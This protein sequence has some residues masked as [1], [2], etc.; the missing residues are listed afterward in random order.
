MG[1]GFEGGESLGAGGGVVG[2]GQGSHA[3]EASAPRGLAD[4]GRGVLQ[5]VCVLG[6]DGPGAAMAGYLAAGGVDVVLVTDSVEAEAINTKGL[7]IDSQQQVLLVTDGLRATHE[8]NP[9][10]KFDLVVLTGRP[11]ETDAVLSRSRDVIAASKAFVSVQNR[12]DPVIPKPEGSGPLIGA[13]ITEFFERLAPGMIIARRPTDVDVFAGPLNDSEESAELAEALIAAFNAGG[14]VAR[15][16]EDI[17]HVMLEKQLQFAN[18]STWMV[19]MLPGAGDFTLVD[20][21]ALPEGAEQWV[22]TCRELLAVYHAMGYQPRDFYGPRSPLGTIAS[23]PDDAEAKAKILAIGQRHVASGLKVR[24]WMHEDI[25]KRQKTEA[26]AIFGPFIKEGV[27]RGLPVPL[28]S[29]ALRAVKIIEASW[30]K[31][32]PV[33]PHLR[34]GQ[35]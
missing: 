30:P 21:M 10:G 4:A 15:R 9:D 1:T 34:T 33:P 28:I 13:S 20:A 31:E 29:A 19:L 3:A 24:T 11:S 14:L 7:V 25:I 35:W 23:T 12:V 18:A 17:R 22:A 27:S 2:S 6:G 26:D 8:P 5:S 32:P 16:P